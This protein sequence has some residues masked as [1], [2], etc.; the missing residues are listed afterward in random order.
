MNV[1]LRDEARDDLVTGAVFYG[2]QSVGLDQ[3]FL[4]CLRE[5]IKKLET[6][7]G[8]HEQYSG[9]HRALSDRFPYAIYYLVSEDVVDVV[10]ILDCRRDP[11]ALNTRLGRTMP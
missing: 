4:K 6:T 11:A 2:E 5:D 1:E 7:G 9:F 10:A 3:Y 8:V